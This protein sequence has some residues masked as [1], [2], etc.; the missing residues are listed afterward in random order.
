MR[1]GENLL[2]NHARDEMDED[3]FTL[4]DLEQSILLG[5]IVER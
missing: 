4:Y 1:Q 5:T 3:D 2:A